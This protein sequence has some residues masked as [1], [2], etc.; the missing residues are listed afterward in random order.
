MSRRAARVDAN[1]PEIV[2]A[3]RS[4]GAEVT[5]LSRVGSGVC[6]LLVS[7]RGNWYAIEIKDG[8]KPPSERKLTPDQVEWHGKQRAKV[9]IATN[10]HEAFD[11]VGAT[12]NTG[13]R[14]AM[15]DEVAR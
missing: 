13:W 4:I 15:G 12:T 7:Y 5:D 3:L 9:H 2:A 6:D 10:I 11:A 14:T 8:R 1:Q